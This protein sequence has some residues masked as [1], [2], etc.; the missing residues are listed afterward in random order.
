MKKFLS[1]IIICML[2]VMP[3]KA[4]E[5][6]LEN[7]IDF[8]PEQ[9]IDAGE[10]VRQNKNTDGS[11]ILAGNDLEYTGN[12]KGILFEAGNDVL[13]N[14]N[15]EYSI[16]AGYNVKLNG[17]TSKDAFLF[18]SMIEVSANVKRD[19]LIF[20]STVTLSGNFDRNVT[21]Y[22]SKVILKDTNIAGDVKINASDIFLEKGV[23]INGKLDYVYQ[24]ASIDSS[25]V[26][27]EVS[28]IK[29]TTTSNV[30]NMI[31]YRAISYGS[32]L[33]VFVC[34]A[35]IVPGCFKNVGEN[36]VAFFDIISYIGYA[37]VF[38]ILVPVLALMLVMLSI[39]IPL[40]LMVF[41]L[42]LLVIYLSYAY[43]GYYIGKQLYKV[44]GLEDNVLL[45]GLLGITILYLISLIPGFGPFVT[46][47]SYLCGIG[48][49]IFKFK[50]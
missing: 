9:A 30:N 29:Q 11:A 22:A 25:A 10:S 2:F 27:G 5:I 31:K 48:I 45:E 37:L 19:I 17:V 3:V 26:I 16:L 4:D 34:L 12:T 47:L 41:A 24:N 33:L 14:G 13:A 6:V 50:K 20:G 39:G 1:L 42:Y 49:I 21:I 18:G 38:I 8:I 46:I 23:I 44:K 35:L 15:S 40:A 32:M 43:F 7:E 36:K 28:G